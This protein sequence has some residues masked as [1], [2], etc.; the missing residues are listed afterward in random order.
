MS[1]QT[2][3]N[4]Y[5]FV[6]HPYAVLENEWEKDGHII[7][8]I[9]AVALNI[10]ATVITLG[11]FQ[12]IVWV[13]NYFWDRNVDVVDDATK[14]TFG[15]GDVLD[16]DDKNPIKPRSFNPKTAEPKKDNSIVKIPPKITELSEKEKESIP[17][18]L[19][20]VFERTP[21]FNNYKLF[22]SQG[23][24]VVVT[25]M[26]L[27][28]SNLFLRAMFGKDVTT[29]PGGTLFKFN[30]TPEQFIQHI[31]EKDDDEVVEFTAQGIK[32][33][34]KTNSHNKSFP[35][36]DLSEVYG[37][38]TYKI[39]YGEIKD[40]LASQ[41]IYTSSLLPL[42]F[43]AE[44]KRAMAADKIVI[45]PGSDG[46]PVKLSQINT[47]EIKKLM[48][49]AEK[50]PGTF[51]FKDADHFKKLCDKTIYQI[52]AM[53]VKTED[54]H[55]FIDGSGNI[56]NRE[57]EAND[58][59]RLIN[60]C[61]IRGISSKDTPAKY[62]KEIMTETFR[63]ALL[64]AENGYVAF[65]AVGMGI[66]RGDPG[67]YWPAFLDALISCGGA[68]DKILV[69]PNHQQTLGGKYKNCNGN[70]FKIILDEYL[71]KYKDNPIAIENLNKIINL[72]AL[73]KDLVQLAYELKQEFP[74]KHVSLFNASDPD[75]TL[76]Y[77]VGEYVNNCP[78]ANTTEENYSAI[79]S[80]VLCFEFHT[81]VHDDPV[82]RF[83]VYYTEDG[84]IGL[85]SLD[86]LLI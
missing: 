15:G 86:E 57:P 75:V 13:V 38:E 55:I 52:G 68:F 4:A 29:M 60:A 83:M 20:P 27:R 31:N 18:E 33:E 56:R 5:N 47:T 64:A 26:K 19:I 44:L 76:G 40:D 25:G 85:V 71:V 17:D 42:V 67:I 74:D 81:G 1:G 51:G 23:A 45:L 72:S 12:G 84:Q 34:F 78:H 79:G 11:G 35:I 32:S 37:K 49:L 61:G 73:G 82:R 16:L 9:T 48:A 41:K 36:N 6:F 28:P 43:Y 53:V 3:F 10:F 66:W 58:A 8:A 77:H 50:H 14:F 69:N 7:L 59:I 24:D 65:P 2:E 46:K 54:Y 39:S 62:N 30:M 63:T 80:N 70:E 22:T 21:A